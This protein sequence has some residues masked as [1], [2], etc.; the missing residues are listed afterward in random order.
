MFDCLTLVCNEFTVLPVL[1]S[2]DPSLTLSLSLAV[3]RFRFRT[4]AAIPD[5]CRAVVV[6]LL[7]CE[8]NFFRTSFSELGIGEMCDWQTAFDQVMDLWEHWT[9]LEHNGIMESLGL[10]MNL[11]LDY[12]QY[13]PAV[14]TLEDKENS[15]SDGEDLTV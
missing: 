15:D 4:A 13:S 12:L 9:D 5:S 7:R 14:P 8:C 1:K 10:P 3:V 2:L 11:L 6:A